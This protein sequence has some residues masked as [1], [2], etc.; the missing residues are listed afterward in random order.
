MLS[1]PEYRTPI[2][3]EDYIEEKNI[4]SLCFNKIL[5]YKE[6]RNIIIK[7]RVKLSSLD[8]EFPEFK[9]TYYKKY[10]DARDQAGIKESEEDREKNFIKYLVE[11]APLDF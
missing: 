8:G 1:Y 9:E 3:T 6:I 4:I 11:D 5:K 10:M 2:F 7:T